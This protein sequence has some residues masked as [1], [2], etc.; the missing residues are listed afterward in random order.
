MNE[1]VTY[2]QSG[3]PDNIEDVAHFLLIAPEKATALR[4][5][6]RAIQKVG[7]AKEVYD[8][9]LEEQRRLCDMILDASV[10][11]GEM[12]KA[13]PKATAGNQYTGK[14]VPDTTVADQ[15]G[16][17]AA[18]VSQEQITTDGAVT[19]SGSKP[20]NSTVARLKTKSDTVRDLGFTP[21]QVERFET[22]A[23]NKDLVELEKATAREEGRMPTRTNVI[24]MAKARRDRFNR[25]IAQ[26]DADAKIAK[27]FVHAVHAPLTISEDPSEIAAAVW[28]NASGKV[29]GDIADIDTAVAILTAIKT[30]LLRG[31]DS[32]GRVQADF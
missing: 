21:K 9:K 14:M 31:G 18:V 25:D 19:S 15:Y 16:A 13:I 20:I 4:A 17:K 3:L 24:D 8:Q 5:E 30:N 6:I 12:T 28:R 27:A 26:I 29:Q 2:Q 1:L 11:L 10:R 23:D 7:L 32:Y 22:L